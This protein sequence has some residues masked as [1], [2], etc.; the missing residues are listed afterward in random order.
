MFFSCETA[1]VYKPGTDGYRCTRKKK[2][3]SFG[4]G[5]GRGDPANAPA[6]AQWGED[7]RVKIAN[8]FQQRFI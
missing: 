7:A 6:A 1:W 2:V 3:S 4:T 8:Y 5:G